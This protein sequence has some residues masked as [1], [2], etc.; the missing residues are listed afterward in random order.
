LVLSRGE[1]GADDA[2]DDDDDGGGF[3]SVFGDGAASGSEDTSLS[4][5]LDAF[6]VPR[7]SPAAGRRS[8]SSLPDESPPSL[9]LLLLLFGVSVLRVV[10][11]FLAL[12]PAAGVSM[13]SWSF[14]LLVR[15]RKGVAFSAVFG[16][17]VRRVDRRSGVFDD[18]SLAALDRVAFL[19]E[20][21]D[22]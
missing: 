2:D 18:V 10:G 11:R 12:L 19:A 13:A 21:R 8:S 3:P 1:A 5:S 22:I 9:S 20:R 4:E 7:V 6:A 17:P 15:D 16:A 14:A